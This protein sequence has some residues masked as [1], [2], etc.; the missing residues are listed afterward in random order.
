[1]SR[2]LAMAAVIVLGAICVPDSA[3]AQWFLDLESG[4]TFAGYNDV[5]IPGRGARTFPSRTIFP[6]TRAP[7]YV[8]AAPIACMTGT[9]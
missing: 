6:P 7:S 5:R 1:M 4:A 2:S 9:T 8:F 3:R